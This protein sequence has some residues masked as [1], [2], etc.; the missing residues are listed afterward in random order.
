MGHVNSHRN[1]CAHASGK[2]A[3]R[4]NPRRKISRLVSFPLIITTSWFASALDEI[5]TRRILREKADCKQSSGQG[6]ALAPNP[7]H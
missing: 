2:A 5:R 4:E 1:V 3:S 7:C 6:L